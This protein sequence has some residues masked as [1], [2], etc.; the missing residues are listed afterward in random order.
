MK[1]DQA[2][3][4]FVGNT[5]SNPPLAIPLSFSGFVRLD[6]AFNT[7]RAAGLSPITVDHAFQNAKVQSWNVNVQ[8]ELAPSLGVIVGYFGSKGRDL[9][10]FLNINQ[11]VS[12][13]PPY[14]RL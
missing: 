4:T 14:P 11:P 1:A 9:R 13:A 2:V 7:A 3:T 12:R 6:S 10:L 8:R 5:T